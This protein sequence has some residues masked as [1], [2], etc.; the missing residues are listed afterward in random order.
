MSVRMAAVRAQ[1][2]PELLEIHAEELEYLWGQRRAA[3]HSSS[4]ILRGFTDLTERVEAHIQGL[5]AIPSA[6]PDLLLPRL[7]GDERDA[8][9]AA[10]CPLLRLSDSAMTARVLAAF[11]QAQG[12]ALAGLRDALSFAPSG[13]FVMA[14]RQALESGEPAHAVAA[15]VILSNQR[16]LDPA[17]PGL[18]GLL[19]DDN[20][21]VAEYAWLAAAEA[22]VRKLPSL[23]SR[24]Y[25]QALAHGHPGVRKAVLYAA[26]WSG[27][28]WVLPAARQLAAAH[29]PV[30]LT[31]LA[32]LGQPEDLPALLQHITS[33]ENPAEG[34]YLLARH[35]H[36]GSMESLGKG[37]ASKDIA[38]SA[39]AGEAFT[40]ITGVDING[41]RQQ[42][43]LGP[44]ADE[45]E[46]EFAELVWIPDM[47]K[48]KAYWQ[49]HGKN[50][51]SGTRWRQGINLEGVCN[52]QSL[53]EVD[54]QAR[55]DA[56][57]RAALAGSPA[58]SPPPIY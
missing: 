28:A 1:Y 26:A 14:M 23:Q 11:A 2:I 46:R 27:Q 31:C 21:E 3:L 29:D 36:P 10:A 41:Q 30:G 56:C 35:G 4:Y 43:P 58:T 8:V 50:L 47:T 9:F 42:V 48:A 37:M 22:D 44:E 6:L 15:A 53:A 5:L 24:P 45:F 7:H 54:L 40:L 57:A 25:H 19:L 13:Q 39:A 33:L 32:A 12:S 17:S 49:Q 52:L 55:W 51:S 16:L 20:P 38:L 18:A 34:Y